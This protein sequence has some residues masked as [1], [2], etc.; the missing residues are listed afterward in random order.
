MPAARVHTEHSLTRRETCDDR[1]AV[2][3]RD[4]D[5][6]SNE[7]C[8]VLHQCG[9]ACDSPV[10][11]DDKYFS[12]DLMTALHGGVDGM[13][14]TSGRLQQDLPFETTTS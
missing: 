5:E 14:F 13:S 8:A 2:H 3:L 11:V 1:Q 9:I 10:H 4:M 12:E 7:N 6:T